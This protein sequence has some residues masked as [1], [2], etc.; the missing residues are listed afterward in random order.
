[1]NRDST[2]LL[3]PCPSDASRDFYALF[4]DDF[5]VPDS[6]GPEAGAPLR[7]LLG[8]DDGLFYAS[9]LIKELHGQR[10]VSRPCIITISWS[11]KAH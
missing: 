9:D 3:K 6:P 2:F 4:A 11:A 5:G 1:M 8:E 10:A 7:G